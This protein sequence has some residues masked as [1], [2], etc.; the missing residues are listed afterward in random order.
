[1][2]G[3]VGEECWDRTKDQEGQWGAEVQGPNNQETPTCRRALTSW[4]WD[5]PVLI[6]MTIM[7]M[8]ANFINP[9]MFQDP[10]NT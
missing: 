2:L 3:N 5:L 4:I 7:M 6:M 8:K 1:M 10:G 9:Q